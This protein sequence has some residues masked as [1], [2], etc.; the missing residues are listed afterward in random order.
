L[1]DCAPMEAFAC[2]ES[3]SPGQEGRKPSHPPSQASAASNPPTDTHPPC[4]PQAPY[5]SPHA[6]LTRITHSLC[7]WRSGG[8]GLRDG[9]ALSPP[10]PPAP[11]ES[12]GQSTTSPYTNQARV[13][14]FI[15][16]LVLRNATRASCDKHIL[17]FPTTPAGPPSLPPPTPSHQ[18]GSFQR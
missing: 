1:C 17:P 4:T 9:L 8:A 16:S 10:Y 15:P 18:E 11:R 12:K 14:T 5:H 6:T 7:R 3:A 2:L 13:Q